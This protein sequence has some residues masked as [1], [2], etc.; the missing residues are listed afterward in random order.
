M[1]KQKVPFPRRGTPEP[2]RPLEW[3][4][5]RRTM[6]AYVTGQDEGTEPY[7]PEADWTDVA[8]PGLGGRTPREAVRSAD[9]RREVDVMLKDMERTESRQPEAQRYDVG[10]LRRELGLPD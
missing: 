2:D 7:R 9:G 8:L 3:V 1:K 6:R 5:G 10:R 4:G